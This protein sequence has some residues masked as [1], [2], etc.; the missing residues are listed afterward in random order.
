MSFGDLMPTH[1][2]RPARSDGRDLLRHR[3]LG[4]FRRKSRKQMDDSAQIPIARRR[5][6]GA[7]PTKH[8]KEAYRET[9][10]TGHEWDGITELDNAAAEMVALC[11]LRHHRLRRGLLRALPVGP[12]HLDAYQ[13][14][15]RLQPRAP[16]WRRATRSP[17]RSRRLIATASPQLSL[18]EI[19]KDPDLLGFAETGGRAVFNENCVPCHRAGGAGAKGY[20][21]LADDDWLWGGT[22]DDIA[23]TITHGVRNAD[24][25]SRQTSD[26]ALRRRRH[27]DARADRATSPITCCR[28]R[29]SRRRADAVARGAKIFADNCVACHGENGNGNHDVGAPNLTDQIWLYGGDRATMVETITYA[30]NGCMPA[31]GARLDP[32]DDQ[33]ADDL[34]PLARR[35]Q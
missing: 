3:G 13:R 23:H 20:P 15:P 18:A 2:G 5:L 22:L 33:D 7:M 35:R 6:R 24:P 17:Q 8:E 16:S 30:R 1:P 12:A 19:R 11:V 25:D 34:R 4:L 31:W 28:S 27:P 14:H 26:A 21:N 10:P 29:A 9:E 32:D